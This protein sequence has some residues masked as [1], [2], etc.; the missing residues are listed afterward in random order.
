[1][2]RQTDRKSQSNYR[3]SW[4]RCAR[5]AGKMV[6]GTYTEMAGCFLGRLCYVCTWLM[7]CSCTATF[8]P[9]SWTCRSPNTYR[10]NHRCLHEII[11]ASSPSFP[12]W[13][14]VQISTHT[15]TGKP[16][17]EAKIVVLYPIHPIVPV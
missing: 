9:G 13:V 12:I 2:H 17:D 6:V 11:V 16:R 1:M 14:R 15:Q 4:P 5:P 8:S 10:H 7:A 3:T